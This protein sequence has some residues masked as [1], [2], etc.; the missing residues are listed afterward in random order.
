MSDSDQTRL[1]ELCS[2]TETQA[3]YFPMENQRLFFLTNLD[4]D[5][6]NITEKIEKVS[7]GLGNTWKIP[8]LLTRSQTVIGK[9]LL[10]WIMT[11]QDILC[12]VPLMSSS[13]FLGSETANRR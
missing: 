3:Q 12:T 6:S 2:D 9:L 10:L 8:P 13:G 1:M 11:S 4:T 7:R 5:T